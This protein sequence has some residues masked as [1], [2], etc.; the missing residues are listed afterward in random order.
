MECHAVVSM[1][2]TFI[3]DV[4]E[5]LQEIGT[6]AVRAEVDRKKEKLKLMLPNFM[7]IVKK[8]MKQ[9][10]EKKNLNSRQKGPR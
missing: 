10:W 9:K 6:R 4:L 8:E 2:K 5:V 7:S 1:Y 3:A